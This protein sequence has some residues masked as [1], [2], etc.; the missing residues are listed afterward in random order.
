MTIDVCDTP[1]A[2]R[3]RLLCDYDEWLLLRT[4]LLFYNRFVH[5]RQ[6]QQPLPM[7]SKDCF[8]HVSCI[9]CGAFMAILEGCHQKHG[10]ISA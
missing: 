7:R 6:Y 9:A 4:R 10:R 3:R 5:K 8:Q 2:N 1:P